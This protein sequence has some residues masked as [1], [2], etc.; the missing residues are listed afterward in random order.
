M[1]SK[2]I[3]E[4]HGSTATLVLNAPQR[5]NAL[6]LDM[7]QAIPEIIAGF[8]RNATVRSIVI[9][10]AGT[11]A[12]AAGADISEFEANRATDDSAKTY[13]LA[14]QAA[15]LSLGRCSKPVIAAVRGICFGGGMALAMACDLRLASDDSRFCIPAA[16]LG[17]GY[18]AP[19]TAALVAL[20]GPSLT[21]EMLFT[22]R[23]YNAAEA[24]SHGIVQAIAPAGQFDEL[25]NGYTAKLAA[26]APLSIAA[27]K[28]AI[29]AAL[30]SDPAHKS[31]A[32]AAVATCMGSDDY[33]EGRRAFLEKRKPV[34]QGR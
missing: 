10:G 13:D 21:A 18:G 31:A 34:F 3:A 23:V 20:F 12:F 33:I 2:L 8:D 22:A 19:G 17:I 32:D 29:R 14:T 24:L 6:S 5:R 26:N 25:V 4:V 16:R 11:E 7:W 28:K 1:T 15:T 30:S 27:A 9:R